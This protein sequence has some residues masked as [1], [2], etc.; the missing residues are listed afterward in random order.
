MENLLTFLLMY[1][2]NHENVLC[3]IEK[4]MAMDISKYLFVAL[5]VCFDTRYLQEAI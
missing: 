4:D 5:L 2:A 1:V 3:N